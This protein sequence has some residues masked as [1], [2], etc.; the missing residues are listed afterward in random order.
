MA[1]E[2][3]HEI[4]LVLEVPDSP[5]NETEPQS[6]YVHYK[7]IIENFQSWYEK[8]DQKTHG[9]ILPLIQTTAPAPITISKCLF[10]Y[11]NILH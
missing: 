1:P 3:I 10:F 6:T 9:F 2:E 7:E 8:S 5:Y 4:A 11:F